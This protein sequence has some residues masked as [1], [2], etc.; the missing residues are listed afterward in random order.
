MQYR[1]MQMQRTA[2]DS[3]GAEQD[4]EMMYTQNVE[5]ELIRSAI[6]QTPSGCLLADSHAI[7]ITSGQSSPSFSHCDPPPTDSIDPHRTRELKRRSLILQV[8]AS[9]ARK[10]KEIKKLI[11][12]DALSSARY[13][14]SASY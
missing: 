8:P 12:E 6:V 2:V 1:S 9:Q 7:S 10:I 3:V 4:G 13:R 11:T 14:M 5:F